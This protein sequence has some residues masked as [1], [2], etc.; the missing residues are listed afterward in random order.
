VITPTASEIFLVDSSGWI[1][2]FGRGPKLSAF[3]PYV[4]VEPNL[5]VPTVVIYEVVKKLLRERG[6]TVA[7]AF[8]SYA[9]RRVVIPF[10]DDL[11]ISAAQLSLTHKLAMADAAIYATALEH[12]AKVVTSD[13]HFLGLSDVVLL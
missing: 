5:L 8:I 10:T 7:D 12:G 11:A 6:K 9:L 4:S 3:L 1:E 2:V 13:Q